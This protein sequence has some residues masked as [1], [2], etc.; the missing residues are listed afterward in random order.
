MMKFARKGGRVK[1]DLW[2]F[3]SPEEAAVAYDALAWKYD[4]WCAAATC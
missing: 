3:S 1:V 4:G 2:Q